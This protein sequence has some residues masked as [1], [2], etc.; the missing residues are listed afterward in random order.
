MIW[1][2]KKDFPDDIKR[3]LSTWKEKCPDYEIKVWTEDNFDVNACKF[4]REAYEN[5]KYAFVSDYVR[6]KVLYDYG[7]IYLDTD[8]GVEKSFDD[9]LDDAEGVLSFE[10]DVWLGTAVMLAAKHAKW[11]EPL[12]KYYENISFVKKNGKVCQTANCA[13]I[14]SYL[15]EY[16]G[17][18]IKEGKQICGGGI[19]I[20]PREYFAPLYY[21]TGEVNKTENTYAIHYHNFSWADKKLM[22]GNKISKNLRK[23]FRKR[24]FNHMENM[25]MKRMIKK[26]RKKIVRVLSNEKKLN[27]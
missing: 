23:I 10:N 3:Y 20:L 14:T 15:N 26:E 7:G 19:L 27:F 25:A 12:I 22:L 4:T 21:L 8:V 6:L 1:F 13:L 9:L 17:L 16:Y 11:L 2:G 5:K 18:K 24:I